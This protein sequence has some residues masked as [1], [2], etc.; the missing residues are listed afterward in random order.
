MSSRVMRLDT[1]SMPNSLATWITEAR[2][3]PVRAEAISGS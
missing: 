1:T 3:M 2:V